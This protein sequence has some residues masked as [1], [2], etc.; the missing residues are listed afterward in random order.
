MYLRPLNR[1]LQPSP[2]RIDS[3]LGDYG[4]KN[5]HLSH[6]ACNLGK[7]DASID[8]FREWLNRI[9]SVTTINST[10]DAQS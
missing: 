2:D 4:P 1:L 10:E 7:S 3:A 5:F 9:R 6:L 8:H